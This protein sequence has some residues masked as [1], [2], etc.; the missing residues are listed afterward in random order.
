A[1]T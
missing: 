1:Q